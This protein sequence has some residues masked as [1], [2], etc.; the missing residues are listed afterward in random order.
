MRRSRRHHR[1]GSHKR[2]SRGHVHRI[3][4]PDWKITLFAAAVGAVAI[5][6]GAYLANKVTFLQTYWYALPLGMAAVGMLLMKRM[7]LVG[8]G[9]AVVGGA[10]GY[11]GYQAQSSSN[12]TSPS[13]KGFS[14]AGWAMRQDSGLRE[15][16]ALIA[17]NGRL[18][19]RYGGAA[20]GAGALI[21][22]GGKDTARHG[23]AASG[24]SDAGYM[25]LEGG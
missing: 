13:A 1:S 17:Q 15:T 24:F 4:N 14:D 7:P 20:S 18:T 23:G 11:E 9:L 22:V 8:I 19:A 6:G 5:I 12:S 2:H 25:G 10:L 16:A 3:H 21:G